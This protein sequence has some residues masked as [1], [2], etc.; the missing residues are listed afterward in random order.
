[1]ANLR[2]STTSPLRLP[3][4]PPGPVTAALRVLYATPSRPLG[5]ALRGWPALSALA[6]IR[7]AWAG[8]PHLAAYASQVLGGDAMLCLLACLT[9]TP[10]L[11]VARVNVA[12]LRWWY[13]TW[14]FVLGAAGLAIALTMTAGP[15]GS[16]AGGNAV[17]WTGLA[18][19]ALLAPMAGT[20]N[21]AAQRVL[22]GEWKRWQRVLVWC[23]WGMTAI[24]LAALRAW[25]FAAALAAATMP[26]VALRQRRFRRRVKDWR[27]GKYSTG[28]MWL[29][30][31]LLLLLYV[32]GLAVLLA[33]EV[34]A[35]V[36]AVTLIP[37]H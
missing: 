10:V 22:G 11:S 13:G 37:A 24:H 6:L 29:V 19:I 35:V 28:G 34:T 9:V 16:R 12:R 8:S 3:P 23:V 1:M 31:D 21:R 26:L 36:R 27:A 18:I 5:V 4:P 30:L 15:P 2:S 7:P 25:P 14:M 20:A 32:T 17:N 33:E